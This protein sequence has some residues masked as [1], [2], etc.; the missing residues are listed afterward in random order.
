MAKLL[1]FFRLQGSSGAVII[2]RD[3]AFFLTDAR[4]TLQASGEVP[5]EVVDRKRNRLLDASVELMKKLSVKRVG[6][7]EIKFRQQ[8]I[9]R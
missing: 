7:Q 4:Y 8:Y 2:T 9:G 5:F 3:R 6:I 1:L